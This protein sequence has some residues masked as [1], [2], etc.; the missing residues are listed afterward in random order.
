MKFTKHIHVL[1]L[2]STVP[3][4]TATGAY[5]WPRRNSS[6]TPQQAVDAWDHLYTYIFAHWAKPLTT[7]EPGVYWPTS[8]ASG[9]RTEIVDCNAMLQMGHDELVAKLESL[10]PYF[11]ESMFPAAVAR[12]LLRDLAIPF[13]IYLSKTFNEFHLRYGVMVIGC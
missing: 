4:A 10:P 11:T 5:D 2:L 1:H 13:N 8:I 7:M 3:A 6:M 9:A 12:F